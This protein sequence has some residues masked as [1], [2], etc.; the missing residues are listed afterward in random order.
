MGDLF[1]G[2]VDLTVMRHEHVKLVAQANIHARNIRVIELQEEIE[3]C[4]NDIEAQNKVIAEA[5]RNIQ[6]H[7]EAQSQKA[8]S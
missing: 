1:S 4:K 6:I 5:D 2:N 7:R 8:S 3:R